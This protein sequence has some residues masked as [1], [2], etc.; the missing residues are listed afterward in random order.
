[1]QQNRSFTLPVS[2]KT[3]SSVESIYSSKR[4]SKPT[5]RTSP[6][7]Q[8]TS[9]VNSSISTSSSSERMSIMQRRQNRMSGVTG[10]GGGGGG[11][12]SGSGVGSNNPYVQ[13][14][15]SGG[16]SKRLSGSGSRS[17]SGKY[18]SDRKF[19]PS[20]DQMSVEELQREADRI[21]NSSKSYLTPGNQFPTIS[22]SN[23]N[24]EQQQQRSE[25]KRHY[26][27]QQQKSQSQPQPQPQPQS[28]PE[29]QHQDR[30]IIQ[31]PATAAQ[32]AGGSGINA[33][34]NLS[35]RSPKKIEGGSNNS[36]RGIVGLQNLGNTCF[37]NS[38]LQCLFNT[39]LLQD[40]FVN[41]DYKQNLCSKVRR[42]EEW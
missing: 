32:P 23:N 9:E 26:L 17:I 38:G 19:R 39:S 6:T 10:N 25:Q 40:Y 34:R 31:N 3:S 15:N 36:L 12:G 22:N 18:N 20:P 29:S 13:H 8:Q 2:H 30:S 41:G 35:S 16:G 14:L 1:M 5:N 7:H 33:L 24:D 11:G 28:Q 27:K 42:G 21:M 4:P 37:M